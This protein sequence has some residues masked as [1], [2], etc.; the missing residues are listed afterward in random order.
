MIHITLG[1]LLSILLLLLNVRLGVR[2]MAHARGISSSNRALL[3]VSLEDI[4]AGKRIAAQHAHV[5]AVT[6]V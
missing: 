5:R 4:A 3:E 1:G 2:Q 6:G